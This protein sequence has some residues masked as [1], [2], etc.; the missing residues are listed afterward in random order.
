MPDVPRAEDLP[1]VRERLEPLP[2]AACGVVPR[3]AAAA[4]RS[5]LHRRAPVAAIG[6]PGTRTRGCGSA[7]TASCLTTRCCTPRSSPTPRTS[8]SS[9]RCSRR[10]K[11]S[12]D[13][14]PPWSPASTT[15]CGSTVRLRADRWLLFDQESPNAY[16]ARGLARGLM[17]DEEGLLVVSL[18]QEGL[19]RVQTGAAA[20]S[21][22][23]PDL[24]H[25]LR[26]RLR[27]L[28][29]VH[30][31][32]GV[33]RAALRRAGRSAPAAAARTRAR[34]ADEPAAPAL[35]DHTDEGC[36][37][38]RNRPTASVQAP[39][40][41]ASPTNVQPSPSTNGQMLLP[42]KAPDHARRRRRAWHPGLSAGLGFIRRDHQR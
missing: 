37:R 2:G 4:D 40:T 20:R 22:R 21:L 27:H 31:G 3:R 15:A 14:P 25:G 38:P 33:L 17:F 6:G 7:P 41:S 36:R 11:S 28:P 10:M 24:E 1:T 32:A 23:E 34:R 19:I 9:T 8:R 18:V 39:N 12:G 26:R 5:A 35:E 30:G 29:R 13:E 42:G 16:G